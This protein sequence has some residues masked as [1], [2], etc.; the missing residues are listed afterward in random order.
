MRKS[1]RLIF[2]LCFLFN[3]FQTAAQNPYN[4]K[5]GR[6]FGG[7]CDACVEVIKQKPKEALFGIDIH[8]NGDVFVVMTDF[9][10]FEKIF[11][12]ANAVTVDIVSKDRYDCAGSKETKGLFK[13]FVLLPLLK[14]D[15]SKN[16]QKIGNNQIQLK[17]GTLPKSLSVKEIEG[18]LIILNGDLVCF[19]S[20]FIN[21]QRAGWELLPMGLYTD[22][23]SKTYSSDE[24]DNTKLFIF[25]K[26]LQ[27]DVNFQKSKTGYNDTDI[28]PLFDSLSLN[29]F[30][31]KK[32]EIRAYSS[33]EGPLD[34]NKRLM[35]GRA[36]AII[37]AF[38]KYDPKL[39]NIKIVT[40]ENWVD[41]ID[42]V[43]KSKFSYLA[44]LPKNEVKRKLTD[45]QILNEI[46]PLLT[47]H[48]KAVITVY[49][50]KRAG[51]STYS[52]KVLGD[53]LNAAI[54]TKKAE[55]ARLVLKEIMQRIED[56]KLP[57]N[58]FNE[59]EIPLEKE[60]VE[61]ISDRE[62]YKYF[63]AQSSEY[64]ALEVFRELQKLDNTNR[65]VNYNVC[66]L[67]IFAWKHGGEDIDKKK[68]FINIE[69]LKNVNV[70]ESL[71]KRMLINYYILISEDYL[72][73]GNYSAKDES[74]LEI[75]DLYRDV[76]LTDEE[77][78]S[79]C[80][81]FALY[82]RFDWAE[83]LIVPRVANLNVNE[84]LLFYFI[85]LSFYYPNR[86]K[87]DVFKAAL[88][89]ALNLNSERYCDFFKPNHK[90]GASFQLLEESIFKTYYCENCLR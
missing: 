69:N 17:V 21:I 53:E 65:A 23:L 4:L 24:L 3:C 68:L 37:T 79:L 18:N 82:S 28:K 72:N 90:G 83:D 45:V 31:I 42:D 10:W 50:E 76:L 49:L 60:F 19:Y 81:Y 39:S 57:D 54:N 63:L 44:T 74:L 25:S 36:N 34:V 88:L 8:Q 14:K 29:G 6:Q 52:N 85:N 66:A 35:L 26:Y 75:K 7:Y 16:I 1:V 61:V 20:N 22:T 64:E 48:R 67:S 43:R 58:Y 12:V 56:N 30:L 46:E 33:V 59:I 51:L 41:F 78:Y 27:Q 62:V 13:G 71:I 38:K 40:A 80:K 84:N 87:N 55:K 70:N 5:D 2:V 32:V 86:Y 77:V 9:F 15:F 47:K 89:N 11:S 73:A